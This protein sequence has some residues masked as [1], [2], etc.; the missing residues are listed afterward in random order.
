M[1]PFDLPLTVR[2]DAGRVPLTVRAA[3]PLPWSRVR[4]AV[5]AAAGLA[6]H[7][8]LYDGPG[9]VPDDW[10]VGQPPLIA[11][12]ELT[13]EPQD[14]IPSRPPVV[15][16]VLAGPD[17]GAWI[18][19]GTDPIRV[20]RDPRSELPLSDPAVSFRHAVIEPTATGLVIHDLGSTNGVVV[21]GVPAGDAA[22]RERR[23]ARRASGRRRSANA[24]GS[25]AIPAHTGSVLR[26]GGSVLQVRLTAEG[27]GDFRPDGAGRLRRSGHAHRNPL[28]APTIP[29]PPQPP[30]PPVRRAVPLVA[31]AAGSLAAGALAVTMRNPLF[32]AFAALGPI[33]MLGTAAADRLRGRRSRRRQHAEYSAANEA[34]HSAAASA[35][36]AARRA[37]WA[38]WPGPTELLWR[39]QA[40][41]P[42]LWER[43][44]SD[45]SYL[46]LATGSG[47][48][49]LR[50]DTA[51]PSPACTEKRR[52]AAPDSSAPGTGTSRTGPERMSAARRPRRRTALRRAA[53]TRAVS[54]TAGHS[55]AMLVRDA[56]MTVLLRG[57]LTLAGPAERGLAR[58]LIAQLA[59]LHSPAD[60]A[61]LVLGAGDDLDPC[62][63]LPHAVDLPPAPPGR[64]LATIA[65]ADVIA[66]ARGR[67]LVVVLD[68]SAAAESD[69]GRA[70]IEAARTARATVPGQ[71]EGDGLGPGHFVTAVCLDTSAPAAATHT[72]AVT[73]VTPGT[74]MMADPSTPTTIGAD[75]FR[76][77]CHAVTPLRESTESTALPATVDLT[78]LIGPIDTAAV[79]ARWREPSLCAVLGATPT[80]AMRLDIVRDG[81]HLLVAGTTG[82]GKSALL[83]TLIASLAV[84]APPEAVTFLLVDYKGGS[85][86]GAISDLP[87]VVGV[88]TDLDP[89][90]SD[91]ALASLG[92]E[93][94]RRERLAAGHRDEA[95]GARC[96]DV[97]VGEADG[98][99]V[100]GSTP[101]GSAFPDLVVVI[102]E[103][104][105]LAV[106]LPGFLA[107]VLDIAQRGRSLGMHLVLATQRPAGVVTPAIRANIGTRICLR[108][109][110]GADSMDVI[111]SADAA[112]LPSQLPGRAIA[113]VGT[114][115][116]TFQT[117]LVS[118]PPP[119]EIQVRP[120]MP[121]AAP[122]TRATPGIHTARGT[123]TAHGR[124][125][126][127]NDRTEQ[128]PA[129]TILRQ[130]ID[131]AREAAAARP[132][133]RRPWLPPLP[134]EFLPEDDQ[135]NCL[136]L[137][138]LPDAQ[139]Q[140]P[141]SAPTSSLLIT[142]PAGAGRSTALRRIA[143][144]EAR[145][146]AEVIV[147]DGD[148]R[149][150][151]LSDWP[152]VTTYLDLTEPRLVLRTLH[153]LADPLR[154][155]A[156]G[157]V[158]CVVISHYDLVAAE[159]ERTDYLAG[160]AALAELPTRA[161][162]TVRLAASGSTALAEKRIA[163]DFP[164]HI[165]LGP[166]GRA[167]VLH[168]QSAG[169][170]TGA[171]GGVPPGRG[172]WGDTEVQVAHCPPGTV[173]PAARGTVRG[174]VAPVVVRP[175]PT[176]VRAAALPVG[177]PAH[178][179]FGIGGD[180]ALPLT[181][182]LTGP[183]GAIVV[184][185]PPR[186]GV[187]AAVTLILDRAAA[188][189]VP[190]IVL[191]AAPYT[192]RRA[193]VDAIDLRDGTEPLRVR[194]A[195]HTGALLVVADHGG[196]GDDYPA[197][198]LLAR[199]LDVCGAGQHLLLGART[200]VL[201]RARRGH[202]RQALASRRGLLL[203]ADRIDGGLFDVT[204][205][206]RSASIPGRGVWIDGAIVVP[207]QIA[208][209]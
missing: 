164:A 205:P 96:G 128:H 140:R 110:D 118:C 80:G 15:L 5:C 90:R 175:L 97:G 152:T 6:E 145:R 181:L 170:R 141:L 186:A 127:H 17:A 156:D 143:L 137:A 149:L 160:S 201:A 190:V 138:D 168:Q 134:S 114:T 123:E 50:P 88:L 166:A 142:G 146:G 162:A 3:R 102:D 111:A 21:D 174:F 37:A 38:T 24:G 153:L 208:M 16:A 77:I 10:T 112:R 46:V 2:T 74:E 132:R 8:Q 195:A 188:T 144:I 61:L 78:T 63:D 81:P 155:P 105:T 4:S 35:V 20:G 49:V 157:H 193:S 9:P 85:A 27:T 45:P 184:A 43:N 165:R 124:R 194:L 191:T 103:F 22:E 189:G 107:G 76:R 126:A 198:A 209:L 200:D 68:G 94:R 206:K 171:G 67:D 75:L 71:A 36:R 101:G 91:R 119:P 12:C 158:R 19:L 122:D 60:I 41:G 52:S 65:P 47:T 108:V 159:L 44:R 109:T 202:L 169:E 154:R 14:D 62:V 79:R 150:A 92:P 82:S 207:A 33:T 180:E 70:L 72:E 57:V 13:T 95:G 84:A 58:W 11:G 18:A 104:A 51:S 100:D 86:F 48:G 196:D 30:P 29:P 116:Q 121:R 167:G 161:G 23:R 42:R 26:I 172:R 179:A 182:D 83:Q 106:E 89:D 115:R 183:G 66:A 53:A 59:C 1:S 99:R 203:G 73:S 133:P 40:T 197:A 176:Q 139:A 28:P 173:P 120:R 136:A 177:D 131:A 163:A 98:P 130:V 185:G 54:G 151:D 178:V 39:A 56:P 125:G 55:S 87:H 135:P 204:L 25:G 113:A 69:L 192:Q 199:F 32:L 7:A 129:V 34:W 147:I 117:A 148:G 64:A 31:A 93:L 187:T